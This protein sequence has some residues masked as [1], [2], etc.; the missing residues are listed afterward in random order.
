MLSRAIRQICTSTN[1]SRSG[2]RFC[3]AVDANAALRA[4]VAQ[5][6]DALIV[7]VVG[8]WVCET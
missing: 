8:A 1:V 4:S 2:R 6:W 3:T 7:R 5:N